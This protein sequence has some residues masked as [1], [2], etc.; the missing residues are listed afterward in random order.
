MLTA[1][2]EGL[3]SYQ[4]WAVF[5][6]RI[7][8]AAIFLAHG[9][10]KLKNL[11]QTGENF[12]AMGFMPGAFWGTFIALLETVGG[13]AV[14]FGVFA[15]PFAALFAGEMLVAALWKMK[16]GQGFIGGYEF[17]LLLM[18]AS[19]VLATFGAGAF[20]AEMFLLGY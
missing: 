1:L 17:D 10:P 20:S 8:V 11:R 7:V 15:Q 5:V 14:L 19:L 12:N 13:L 6:L 9:L 2:L 3:S 18:A 16:R 4:E